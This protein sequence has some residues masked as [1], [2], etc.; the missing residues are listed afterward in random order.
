MLAQLAHKL[1]E[2]RVAD[3][4]TLKRDVVT[5]PPRRRSAVAVV[6]D[7]ELDRDRVVRGRRIDGGAD[8]GE[9]HLTARRRAGIRREDVGGGDVQRGDRRARPARGHSGGSPAANVSMSFDKVARTDS[10]V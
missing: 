1:E 9:R 2:R 8:G 10:T 3:V 6:V 7:V 5:E 4:A